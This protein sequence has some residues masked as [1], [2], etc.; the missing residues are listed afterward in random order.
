MAFLLISKPK[1]FSYKFNPAL[2]KKYLCSQDMIKEPPCK[3]VFISDGEIY[4]SSGYLYAKGKDP[5]EYN[6]EVAPLIKYMYGYAILFFGNP[7]IVQIIFGILFLV[8]TYF[9]GLKFTKSSEIPLLA[10]IFLILDPLF[11]TLSST[12]LL[13]MGQGVF[14]L[15]YLIL[16][17]YYQ[18]NIFFRVLS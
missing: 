18:K 11:L 2:L 10:C 17:L 16:M 6:F 13:D 7:F 12:I 15:L 4:L 5:T 14:L 9:F 8:L 1:I 3:R